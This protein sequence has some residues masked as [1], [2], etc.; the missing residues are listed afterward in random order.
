M[1]SKRIVRCPVC[2]AAHPVSGTST[3]MIYCGNC[4]QK[5]TI[6]TALPSSNDFSRPQEDL[7]E[8]NAVHI[9][10]HIN[11]VILWITSLA[12]FIVA[13]VI[14]RPLMAIPKGPGFLVYYSVFFLF[15]WAAVIFIRNYL[16]DHPHVT[17]IGLAIFEGIGI[18]RYFDASAVGMK[19]FGML[20]MMMVIGGLLLF[21]RSEH[22]NNRGDSWSSTDAGGGCS[23]GCGSGCGGCGG[24]GG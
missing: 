14:A 1:A 16:D 18:I 6:S 20:L 4:N 23:S 3:G 10:D 9:P 13:L 12:V 24:C 15:L 21:L 17:L 22:I 8:I 7:V 2:L 5:F 11:P 19:N